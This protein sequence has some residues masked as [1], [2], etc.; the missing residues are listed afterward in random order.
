MTLRRWFFRTLWL[1]DLVLG[2]QLRDGV[3]TLHRKPR[4][5]GVPEVPK[6]EIDHAEIPS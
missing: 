6:K 5:F 3:V 1:I 4:R 2:P